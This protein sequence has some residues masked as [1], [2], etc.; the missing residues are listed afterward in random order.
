MRVKNTSDEGI[1]C[2]ESVDKLLQYKR[3]GIP[4]MPHQIEYLQSQGVQVND[5]AMLGRGKVLAE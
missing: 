1:T 3:K 2:S 4:L 5:E